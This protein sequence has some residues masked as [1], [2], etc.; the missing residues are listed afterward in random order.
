MSSLRDIMDVDIEPLPQTLRK[1]ARKHTSPDATPADQLTSSQAR[2]RDDDEGKAPPTK[3]R[4]SNRAG[5]P[6]APE[7]RFSRDEGSTVAGR[8][9]SDNHY[10]SHSHPNASVTSSTSHSSGSSKILG[11]TIKYTPVTGRV[12]KAKKGQP[13]HVCEICKPHKTFT[14]AEH[15]RRHQLSHT[16]PSFPCTY[17]DCE[18]AF[19]RR[20]LLTRHMN[21]Q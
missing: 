7:A 19:H 17:Q 3:R 8:M 14:R 16:K 5:L 21:R 9:D 10:I 20:D 12:S 6:P 15:L 1:S 13:V 4:R 11:G 2:P 18:R